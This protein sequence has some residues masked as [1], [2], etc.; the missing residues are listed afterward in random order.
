M[1]INE[2]FKPRYGLSH[3]PNWQKYHQW[4]SDYFPINFPACTV[5]R[6]EVSIDQPDRGIIGWEL[7]KGVPIV[8]RFDDTS[9]KIL[10]ELL[11]EKPSVEDVSSSDPDYLLRRDGFGAEI[12][13]GMLGF[14]FEWVFQ[15]PLKPAGTLQPSH[16]LGVVRVDGAELLG[17]ET[18]ITIVAGGRLKE[19]SKELIMSWQE[20]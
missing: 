11:P 16:P 20:L 2:I 13:S 15:I 10:C 3:D 18:T 6:R 14:A 17:K 8:C 19:R 12:L 4:P 7:E 5:T 1:D 9:G